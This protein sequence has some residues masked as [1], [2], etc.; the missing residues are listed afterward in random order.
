VSPVPD[1]GK[2]HW[3]RWFGLVATCLSLVMASFLISAKSNQA[4]IDRE[5]RAREE[6]QRASEAV[7]CLIIITLDNAY[8]ERYASLPKAWKGM[9]DKTH[10]I[11][12]EHRCNG[13]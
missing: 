13:G 11:R 8:Q 5:R 1:D 6:S 2:A 3:Y 7:L 10:Q 4:S 9:A 12:I